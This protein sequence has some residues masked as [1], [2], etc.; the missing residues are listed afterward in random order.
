MPFPLLLLML[1]VGVFAVAQL[2]V[3]YNDLGDEGARA[4]KEAVRSKSGFNL[5]I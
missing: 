2:D 1:N 4:V 5:L 3:R